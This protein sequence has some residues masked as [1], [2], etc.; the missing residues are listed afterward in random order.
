MNRPL[1]R[2]LLLFQFGPVHE[3]L[4]P[5]FISASTG[6]NCSIT[7]SLH[8]GSRLNKGDIFSALDEKD[9]QH[10]RVIYRDRGLGMD[11]LFSHIVQSAKQSGIRHVLFLTLQDSWTVA[12]A[13]KVAA[14]GLCVL[15]I[16]H[17]VN[18]LIENP[19][20]LNFWLQHR[21]T[22]LVLSK[23]VASA[24]SKALGFNQGSVRILHSVFTPSPHL[25]RNNQSPDTSQINIGITG[26]VNYAN[27]PFPLL[28]ETFIT[29]LRQDP[30][31]ASRL[32]FQVLGGGKDLARLGQDIIAAGLERHFCLP[33]LGKGILKNSYEA[34]FQRLGICDYV[35]CMDTPHYLSLKI[36]SAI[37][38][39]ISFCK[40]LICSD[41]LSAIYE[42]GN[43]SI[44]SDDLCVALA[45]AAQ[46]SDH[47][48]CSAA[49]ASMRCD[50]I[51]S[52]ESTIID[53]V[54]SG[55]SPE[56]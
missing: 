25:L 38:T 20:V 44:S 18:K 10:H 36:T 1:H 3:E 47:A 16:I 5:L 50:A 24:V 37:P 31:L 7:A 23:H 9:L 13:V 12:L 11:Q 35:L 27:R 32:V 26:G 56:Q 52:N 49:A 8:V 6:A 53:L 17:N 14:S 22:P 41:A 43:M 21:A 42:V 46:H 28:I 4:A 19:D 39:A 34:Y 48:R 15:G 40:P 29:L 55:L 2:K 33:Q 30:P 51:R 54:S 45:R